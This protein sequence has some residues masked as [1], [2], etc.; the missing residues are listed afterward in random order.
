VQPVIFID[1][2]CYSAQMG[3]FGRL[4]VYGVNFLTVE[5]PP[6]SV[7]PCIPEGTYKL[8]RTIY[9]GGDGEGG[10]EDYP[11]YE[12]ENVVDRTEIKLHIGNTIADTIGCPL[13]GESLGFVDGRW[14]VTNSKQSFERFM[15]TMAGREADS[16]RISQ[17]H[18]F[19]G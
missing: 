9:Y 1:R 7:T 10:A 19:G 17:R 3:T 2:F 15:R 18:P 4:I 8:R 13:V 14:A 12:I 5:P 6:R 16:I 11:C